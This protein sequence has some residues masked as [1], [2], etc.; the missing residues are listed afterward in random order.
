MK[1]SCLTFTFLGWS[2]LATAGDILLTVE[3]PE[4]DK[5]YQGVANVRGWAIASAGVDRIEL[6]V[7]GDYLTDIPSGAR[8]NDVA[9]A[10]PDYPDSLQSGF[11][12]V[13]NY[14]KLTPGPHT[15]TIRVV[16]KEG[17]E[18]RRTV[19]FT[20]IRFSDHYLT[21]DGVFDL[22]QANVRA[23]GNQVFIDNLIVDG[24]HYDAELTWRAE[25]QRYQF[26]DIQPLD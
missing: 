1:L 3:A 23:A 20:A 13:Y 8:R 12:M 4:M 16:D 22:S 19:R 24:R 21:G 18:E 11:S 14:Q 6:F 15:M 10:F 26:T 9:Q 17:A 5:V 2:A 25:S 7:D